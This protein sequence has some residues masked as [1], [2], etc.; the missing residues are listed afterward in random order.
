MSPLYLSIGKSYQDDITYDVVDMDACHLLLGRTWL[1]DRNVTHKGRDNTYLFLWRGC[2]I[3]LLPFVPSVS[4]SKPSPLPT[5]LLTTSG[6]DFSLSLKD[7]H[8]DVALLT[9]EAP[10]ESIDLL[11][12]IHDVLQRYP[13]IAPTELPDHFPPMRHI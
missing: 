11:S 6:A 5:V 2:K 8:Y 3:A 12:A 4:S 7:S 10:A 1:F 9:K 13:T